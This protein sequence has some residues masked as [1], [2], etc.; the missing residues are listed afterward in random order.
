MDEIKP[1]SPEVLSSCTL[2]LA[3]YLSAY[4]ITDSQQLFAL[5]P[6][7]TFVTNKY[8]WNLVTSP[9]YETSFLK[10]ISYIVFLVYAMKDVRF[11]Y[12]RIEFFGLY[13]LANIII[14][15]IITF[16]YSFIMFFTSQND[17][18]ITIPSYG[19]LGVFISFAMFARQ[20]LK[21]E[22]VSY[23]FPFITYQ[24][25]PIILLLCQ[26]IFWMLGFTSAT[27]DIM[28]GT[29]SLFT[30]WSYLRF[31]YQFDGF[32]NLPIPLS[33]S[34]VHNGQIYGDDS[35]DFAFVNMFPIVS[36]STCIHT[37]I[38]F[39]KYN[40]NNVY[41]IH[42]NILIGPAPCTSAIFDVFL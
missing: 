38:H 35:D 42:M 21:N 12:D 20:Q 36:L 25:Y 7:N 11:S 26:M 33:T 9:F 4:F 22:T 41:Y 32:M 13:I 29:I 31:Y 19:F 15:S 14:C 24:N 5:V 39:M 16:T 17:W 8:I 23:I 28:F 6:I 40:Y 30:S 3:F 1:P 27:S 2:L 34:R 37:Y 10:V 18:Y